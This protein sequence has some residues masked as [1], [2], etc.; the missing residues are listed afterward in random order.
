[1]KTKPSRAQPLTPEDRRAS[2]LDAAV[3]LLMEFGSE[4]TTRQ[5]A[6]AAGVA[7][8][9]LFRVF[10]DKQAIIDAAVAR[11][12]DPTPTIAALAAI[13]TD[14]NLEAKVEQIVEIVRRRFAGVTGIL[15]ALGLREPPAAL[16]AKSS[17][18]D[19]G[20]SA[21]AAI[22]EPHRAELRVEPEE[23]VHMLR[24]LCLAA[25]LP[26]MGAIRPTENREIVD[27]VLHGVLKNNRK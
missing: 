27:V 3:P 16:K 6:D 9:T 26:P 11:F 2:I 20:R 17:P 7:E 22:L 1:V 25:A 8:G 24:L 19:K 12:L 18:G 13:E 5:L 10:E 14:Q 4:V 23:V 15:T 21:A